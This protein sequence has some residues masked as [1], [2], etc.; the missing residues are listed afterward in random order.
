MARGRPLQ[1]EGGALGS[2]KTNLAGLL[3]GAAAARLV[4]DSDSGEELSSHWLSGP[5]PGKTASWWLL[6][7]IPR[8]SIGNTSLVVARGAES[9]QRYTC[10]LLLTPENIDSHSQ[11]QMIPGLATPP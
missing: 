2:P 5:P 11:Y 7:T 10:K 8:G 9:E 1:V 3:A 6:G 4:G